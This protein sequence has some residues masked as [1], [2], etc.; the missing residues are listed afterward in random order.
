MAFY[1][2]SSQ[3]PELK[4]FSFTE[5]AQILLLATSYMTVPDK[6][7]LNMA[8]LCVLAPIFIMVAKFEEWWMLIPML[9][10]GL[11]Y[12]LITNPIQ[13]NLAKKHLGKAIKT[14]NAEKADQSET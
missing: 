11:C 13:L 14:F 5:R 12:P 4:S 10:V 6:F 8:K 2:K 1:L 9:I 7:I 3:I